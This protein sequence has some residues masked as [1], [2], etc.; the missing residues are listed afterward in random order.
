MATDD[1]QRL[2]DWCNEARAILQQSGSKKSK[3]AL[4][5]DTALGKVT[6]ALDALEA[7]AIKDVNDKSVPVPTVITELTTRFERLA[8]EAHQLSE[9]SK[10]KSVDELRDPAKKITENLEQL[11]K[12]MKEAL[13]QVQDRAKYL[14]SMA[15]ARKRK[16]DLETHPYADVS[17]VLNVI[18]GAVLGGGNLEVPAMVT[19]ALGVLKGLDKAIEQAQKKQEQAAKAAGQNVKDECAC[20]E[21]MRLLKDLLQKAR[22]RVGGEAVAQSLQRA[23]E[24]AQLKINQKQWS[25][26]LTLLTDSKLPDETALGKSEKKELDKLPP[27]LVKAIKNGLASYKLL[28]DESTFLATEARANQHI[29]E[30]MANAEDRTIILD[31]TVDSINLS[32]EIAT[33]H[34]T[35]VEGSIRTI[36][37]TLQQARTVVPAGESL[38]LGEELTRVKSLLAQRRYESARELAASLQKRSA[39]SL[40]DATKKKTEWTN[41]E[42]EFTTA[43]ATLRSHAQDTAAPPDAVRASASLVLQAS[44]SRKASLVSVRDWPELVALAEQLKQ[45]V[46]AFTRAKEQYASFADAR[47]E[48]NERFG[49]AVKAMQSIINTTRQALVAVQ[50][51]GDS[52]A[53]KVLAPFGARFNSLQERWT[54]RLQNATDEAS[55]G[56]DAILKELQLLTD[57]LEVAGK[58]ESL[59]NAKIA[60]ETALA[61]KSFENEAAPMK[62]ILD[63]LD[64]FDPVAGERLAEELAAL[65][66]DTQTSWADRLEP[67]KALVA[68]ARLQLQNRERERSQNNSA[69]AQRCQ[70]LLQRVQAEQKKL[71]SSQDK[72]FLPLFTDL[73]NE[74]SDLKAMSSTPNIE[75]MEAGA[76]KLEE[77]DRQLRSL[78]AIS[79]KGSTFAPVR[80]ALEDL[81]TALKDATDVLQENVPKSL[82]AL[83]R[84][85]AQLK[86]DVLSQSPQDALDE[87]SA[88]KVSVNLARTEAG[89][90]QLQRKNLTDLVPVI[91]QKIEILKQAGTM[92]SYTKALATRLQQ[93][94]AQS[95]KDPAKIGFAKQQ[96]DEIHHEV[97]AAII[98]PGKGLE[99]QK[100]MLD[101]DEAARLLA[102]Q[103]KSLLASAKKDGLA[104]ARKAVSTSDNGDPALI[105]ELKRMI[106]TVSDDLGGKAP[107]HTDILRRLR[108]IEQRIAEIESDPVGPGIGA[109]KSLPANAK[110]FSD[111]ARKLLAALADLPRYATEKVP[112]LPK[113]VTDKLISQLDALG[114]RINPDQFVQPALELSDSKQPVRHRREVRE[115]ALERVRATSALINEHPQFVALWKNPIHVELKAIAS[116]IDQRLRALEANIRRAVH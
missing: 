74:L 95:K 17:D 116:E 12:D 10:R 65:R 93:A 53:N 5:F 58:P 46:L 94:L 67:L 52:G 42:G 37:T 48:A 68:K 4:K 73:T 27:E 66:A 72:T 30:A 60:Q 83:T 7:A 47:A 38:D 25:A 101:K 24:A 15:T 64:E 57:E 82:A 104:R 79:G 39:K 14:L 1:K 81:E 61:Q 8:Q 100:A 33:E 54:A 63:S 50:T 71:K 9:M 56:V 44:E 26:A 19:K 2:I 76:K 11:A 78:E 41:V 45:G 108:L 97:E 106:D 13:T 87:I 105:T 91:E 77:I 109:R 18:N 88:V 115:A 70:D 6:T 31:A 111:S 3:G 103:C 96:L 112:T 69:M 92:Q 86:I 102:V 55:L 99:Q 20:L 21:K 59:E 51:L 85:I 35:S 114:N 75:V 32:I 28:A 84:T 49:K 29:Q 16:A 36:E 98:D 90:V 23:I 107:D 89:K 110:S 34:K 40:D 43:L 62:A 80:R 22:S 113:A